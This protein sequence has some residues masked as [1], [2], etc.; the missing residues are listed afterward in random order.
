M[1]QPT[2]HVSDVDQITSQMLS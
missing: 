2:C 1:T